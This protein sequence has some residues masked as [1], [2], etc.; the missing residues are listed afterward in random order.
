MM[1]EWMLDLCCTL[2][3][4]PSHADDYPWSAVE[5]L[6]LLEELDAIRNIGSYQQ[7][8]PVL[9][10]N[11]HRNKETEKKSFLAHWSS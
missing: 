11:G 10:A 2:G 5:E 3:N 7:G 8:P 6:G 9:L 4:L 1:D